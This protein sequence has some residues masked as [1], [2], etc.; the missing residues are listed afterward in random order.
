MQ[1]HRT[2]IAPCSTCP[3]IFNSIWQVAVHHDEASEVTRSRYEAFLVNS[4]L[5]PV[6]PPAAGPAAA[7]P[8][9]A[10]PAAAAA[11]AVSTAAVAATGSRDLGMPDCGYGSFHQQYWLDGRLVAVGVVDVLPRWAGLKGTALVATCCQQ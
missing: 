10:A 1:A 7:A 3:H 2:S 4:P 6:P 5:V 11:A 8:G 9:A